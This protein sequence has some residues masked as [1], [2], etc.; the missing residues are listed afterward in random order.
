MRIPDIGPKLNKE[1]DRLV[2][3]RL[4]PKQ[5]YYFISL[6]AD[7]DGKFQYQT[8]SKWVGF[9]KEKPQREI[10]EVSLVNAVKIRSYFKSKKEPAFV[11]NTKDD[12]QL[13]MLLTGGHGIIEEKLARQFIHSLFQPQIFSFTFDDG[14]VSVDSIPKK[15]FNRAADPKVR[16]KVL[17]RD[18]RRCMICGASPANNEHVEL[19]LHHIIPFGVGGITEENNLITVCHTCHKGLYPEMDYSLFDVIGVQMFEKR[20]LG[21]SNSYKYKIQWNIYSSLR[22]SSE[23]THKGKK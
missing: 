13:F 16:M 3:A 5:K 18:R 11:I 17:N 19:H 22:H 15:K 20:L 7:S 2:K 10:R 12:L 8:M 23:K 14:W 9:T 21:D 6:F 4:L 1:I